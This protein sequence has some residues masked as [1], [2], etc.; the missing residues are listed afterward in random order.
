MVKCGLA[1][2]QRFGEMTGILRLL[3]EGLQYTEAC[4]RP[5]LGQCDGVLRTWRPIDKEVADHHHY[6]VTYEQYRQTRH[7][8]YSGMDLGSPYLKSLSTNYNHE[9]RPLFL[10]RSR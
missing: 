6:T 3:V 4:S 5:A 7:E 2:V 8:Q 1:H 9:Y 10:S